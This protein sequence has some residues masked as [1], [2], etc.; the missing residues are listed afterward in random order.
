[1]YVLR[2]FWINRVSLG[3][4]NKNLIELVFLLLTNVGFAVLIFDL[5]F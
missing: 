5:V 1:M 3:R 4:T 2:F